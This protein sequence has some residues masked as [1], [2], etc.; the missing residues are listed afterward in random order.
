LARYHEPD[1]EYQQ[2]DAAG[3]GK[4][5]NLDAHDIKN[6]LPQEKEHQPDDGRGEDG[7][8]DYFVLLPPVKVL[9]G[10]DEER[11]VAEGIDNDEKRHESHYEVMP[12][13]SHGTSSFPA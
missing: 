9:P 10:H 4:L 12:E 8:V 7:I 13:I 3:D 11:Q 6:E 2:D 1:R 5:L